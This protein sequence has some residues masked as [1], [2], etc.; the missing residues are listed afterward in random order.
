[1]AYSKILIGRKGEWLEWQP[2]PLLWY[3]GVVKLRFPSILLGFLLL[4]LGCGRGGDSGGGVVAFG[5]LGDAFPYSHWEH[6]DARS[7]QRFTLRFF[8]ENRFR[9][10]V[11]DRATPRKMMAVRGSYVKRG[12]DLIFTIDATTCPAK[13][14]VFRARLKDVRLRDSRLETHLP[15]ETLS[16]K[17]TAVPVFGF[18]EIRLGCFE[19]DESFVARG[20]ESIP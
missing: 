11:S 12:D 8:G 18:G 4:L 9:A 20:W 10:M 19:T 15:T 16:L 7:A 17:Q 5:S 14:N 2:H 1:M 3:E 13:E 6:S